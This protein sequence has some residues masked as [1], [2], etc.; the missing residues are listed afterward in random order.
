MARPPW[1]VAMICS[2][3]GRNC[4]LGQKDRF[5]KQI[6]KSQ[7]PFNHWRVV[8]KVVRDNSKKWS[9]EFLWCLWDASWDAVVRCEQCQTSTATRLPSICAASSSGTKGQDKPGEVWNI[10][11]IFRMPYLGLTQTSINHVKWNDDT[12]TFLHRTCMHLYT[13]I[14]SI[15]QQTTTKNK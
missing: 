6:E 5:E 9:N 14:S 7:K 11:T 13:Y 1:P 2:G 12:N 10:A 3:R 4:S 15:L 8:V